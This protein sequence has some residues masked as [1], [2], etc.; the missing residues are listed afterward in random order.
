[1]NKSIK[2]RLYPNKEQEKQF[3][4]FAD[5]SRF[6]YNWMLNFRKFMY[7]ADKFSVSFYD[8]CKWLS[9]LKSK[10][11]F[12]EEVPT[13]TL[14]HPLK[15]LDNAYKAFFKKNSDYP[16][17]KKKHNCKKSFTYGQ[18]IHAG[19][20][21]INVA[22]IG[23]IYANWHKEVPDNIKEITVSLSASGKWHAGVV[24]KTEDVSVKSPAKRKSVGIDLGLSA[25]AIPSH[26][27]VLENP[28]FLDNS[29]RKLKLLQRGQTRKTKGSNGY[30]RR[31]LRIARLHE[32]ISASRKFHRDLWVHNIVNKNQVIVLE[33][34][35]VANLIK[36]KNLSRSLSDAGLGTIKVRI[37]QKAKEY[38]RTI[39]FSDKFF[40]SSKLCSNCGTKNE[41]LTLSIR[42]WTCA[43]GKIHNRDRNAAFNLQKLS[44][45]GSTGY[46]GGEGLSGFG[47]SIKT[48]SKV[49]TP[50]VKPE[51]NE[52]ISN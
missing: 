27:K 9:F 6:V 40:P 8:S 26:G 18:T 5:G 10:N 12:L 13:E 17:F 47:T 48:C 2:I 52:I 46:A 3:I 23:K 45:V 37:E 20:K 51:I 7:E 21:Y 50:S 4:Q 16:V 33:D 15:N 32:K 36:N 29:S 22:G 42:N 19:P 41:N 1:M 14:R 31:K 44:T 49:E 38:G 30:N 24:Y 25:L 35:S 28:K 11:K 39:I 34:L 43:C